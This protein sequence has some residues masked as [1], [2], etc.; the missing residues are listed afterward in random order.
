MS[1]GGRKMGRNQ[2]GF[3]IQSEAF[4]L[5]SVKIRA[6]LVPVFEHKREERKK[7]KKED[8]GKGCES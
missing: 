1:A 7:K 4:L 8:E 6:P 5:C 3:E 2:E